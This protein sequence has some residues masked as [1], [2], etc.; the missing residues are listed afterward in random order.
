MTAKPLML[1]FGEIMMR[2][3]PKNNLRIEQATQFDV[4]YGGAEANAALFYAYQG[5]RAAYVS[6]VPDNRIGD[7]ALR[8]LSAYGVD[9]SRVVRSG[10]RLGTYIF[11]LGASMRGN[12]CIYDRKY[13]AI[14]LARRETFDWDAIL[15]GVEIFYFS[16]ITCAISPNMALACKDALEACRARKITTVCDVNYRGKMWTPEQSQRVMRELLSLVDV[17]IANDEDAPA[18]IGVTCVS[19]SLANG[20]AERDDYLEMARQLCHEYGCKQVLSVIRDIES[21]ERSQWM[22]MLYS[23]ENDDLLAGSSLGAEKHW[24]SPVHNVHVLEG[25]AAGDAF[26]GA[27]LH[28]LTCGFAGQEAIDYAIAGSVLKLTIRGD[29]NLVTESEIKAVASSVGAGARVQR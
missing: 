11:E 14:N 29:S 4:H 28:A 8:S 27:Y 9:T 24:F 22:G 7:C 15:E 16:G 26:S 5:G 18:G 10:D 12:G 20:I 6:V 21:V 25:V 17:V 23:A 2:L 3:S 19:G 1:A 13:S